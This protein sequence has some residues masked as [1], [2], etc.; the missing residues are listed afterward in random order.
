MLLVK[1]K[2]SHILEAQNSTPA[3][4]CPHWS[5]KPRTLHFSA[6]SPTDYRSGTV[7]VQSGLELFRSCLKTVNAFFLES[8]HAAVYMWHYLTTSENNATN[9]WGAWHSGLW[10]RWLLHCCS[11]SWDPAAFILTS[12]CSGGRRNTRTTVMLSVEPDAL[13]WHTKCWATFDP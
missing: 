9:N 8:A 10:V 11:S 1:K 6:Q 7:A 3:I 12:S 4:S 5:S 2:T 13:A